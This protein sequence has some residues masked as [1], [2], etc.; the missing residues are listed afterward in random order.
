MA[1]TP[2][3]PS[4]AGD[5]RDGIY[6]L[7]FTAEDSRCV[8]LAVPWEAT[9]SYGGGT[10]SGP[11]AI[12]EASEQVDLYDLELGRVYEPGIH[13]LPISKEV[14]KWS[15]QGRKL[16]DA[17]RA[18]KKPPKGK[19]TKD[20]LVELNA[21]GAKLNSWVRAESLK[22]MKAG[23]V[24]GLLGGDH[25]TPFGAFEA[26]G[27]AYGD[28]GILHFDA[29]SDTRAAYCGMQ[30]SHASIMH[31]ALTKISKVRKLTQVGIRDF[32]ED[33]AGFVK[34]QGQRAQVFFDLELKAA[35]Y[36][37][38][39]WERTCER[40]V[41]TLPP[42]VWVSFDIDGLDPQWC[43][44]TGTPVPGGLDYNQALYVLR[45]L[46]RSGR[47]IVGFDLNEVAPGPKGDEWD[48]NV[49]ARLLYKMAGWALA[50]N[51]ALAP[52]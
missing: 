44:H 12:L 2:F 30:W 42:Q 34:S 11:Q 38:E 37:G 36:K 43:P 10:S 20:P 7:P 13:L 27:E 17:V 16:A 40:I 25:S 3:D 46:G 1:L 31:N 6:G 24:V 45:T 28:F 48:A 52:R 19:K 9:T 5:W 14:A 21:L 4:G 26:A 18:G 47:K 50:S 15:A 35:A 8:I 22:W 51:G 29:H 23:K 32:S 41:S 49:G 39:S 33:E